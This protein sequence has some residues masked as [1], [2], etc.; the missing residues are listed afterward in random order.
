MNSEGRIG[1]NWNFLVV[2]RNRFCYGFNPRLVILF[3]STFKVSL[4][5]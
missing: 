3:K 1:Y 5:L 2:Y 4:T